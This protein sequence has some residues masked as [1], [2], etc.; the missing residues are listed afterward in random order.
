MGIAEYFGSRIV[1]L[2][3]HNLTA[4]PYRG[5]LNSDYSCYAS[6]L[7]KLILRQKMGEGTF[8]LRETRPAEMIKSEA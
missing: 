3:S 8:R 1:V 6:H 2:L 7:T 4:W 5:E